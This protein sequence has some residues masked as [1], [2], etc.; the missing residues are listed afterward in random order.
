MGRGEDRVVEGG[1]GLPVLMYGCVQQTGIAPP[2]HHARTNSFQLH[3]SCL[4][5]K[6]TV[7]FLKVHL[8]FTGSLDT[9]Y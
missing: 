4:F 9:V 5:N 7:M 6:D 2:D 1:G 3:M 8:I